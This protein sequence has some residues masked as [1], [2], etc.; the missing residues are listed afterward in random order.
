LWLAVNNYNQQTPEINL[1]VKLNPKSKSPGKN[2][3]GK[4]TTTTNQKVEKRKRT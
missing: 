2:P 3:I 4:A 1:N